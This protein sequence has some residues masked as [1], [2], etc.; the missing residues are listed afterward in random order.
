PEFLAQEFDAHVFAGGVRREAL[1]R[2]GQRGDAGDLRAL[3]PISR[4]PAQAFGQLTARIRVEEAEGLFL[5]GEAA[6]AARSGR[7]I[8]PALDREN[9]GPYVRAAAP[10]SSPAIAIVGEFDLGERPR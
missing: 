7:R 8:A 4:Q 9:H 3:D 10:V 2:M 1:A 6:R 5:I